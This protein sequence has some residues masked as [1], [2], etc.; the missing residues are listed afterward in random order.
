MDEGRKE[1]RTSG[2]KKSYKNPLKEIKYQTK[3][4]INRKKRRG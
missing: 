4:K 1:K 3:N 2:E